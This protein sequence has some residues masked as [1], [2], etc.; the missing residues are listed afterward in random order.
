[1]PC[2]QGAGHRFSVLSFMKLRAFSLNLIFRLCKRAEIEGITI[3]VF[4]EKDSFDRIQAKLKSALTLLRDYDTRRFAYLQRDVKRIMVFGGPHYRGSWYQECA[5]CDL[6][7]RY[8]LAPE[9]TPA[10]LASTLAHEAMHARLYRWGIGY[11]Q[12]QRFRVER[13]C[14]KASIAFARRLPDSESASRE[15]IIHQAQL[16]INR[17]PR[18]WTDAGRAERK[19]AAIRELGGPEW[20]LCLVG[21]WDMYQLHRHQRLR[22]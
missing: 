18:I 12:E 2:P 21:R 20:L 17:D 1:M 15:Y 11:N 6:T 14:F 4:E 9:T 16:Q 22:K 19:L 8:V 13:C 10:M 3:G 5:M 7:D